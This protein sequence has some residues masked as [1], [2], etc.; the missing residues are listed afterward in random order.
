MREFRVFWFCL[1]SLFFTWTYTVMSN[2]SKA[3][4]SS[5]ES[6]TV[7]SQ[8]LMT[9]PTIQQPGFNRPGQMPAFGIIFLLQ[10]FSCHPI[11]NWRHSASRDF[12]G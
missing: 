3:W 10:G 8:L 2:L 11:R 4:F 12:V 5:W 1:G 7:V 9:D 6:A